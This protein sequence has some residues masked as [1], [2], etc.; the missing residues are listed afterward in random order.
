MPAGRPPYTLE[1]LPENWREILRTLGDEGKSKAHACV[2]LGISFDTYLRFERDYPEFLEA[3]R[4]RLIRTEVW[5]QDTGQAMAAGQIE[6]GNATA[7]VFNMKN[8]FGWHDRQHLDHSSS[9][10]SMSPPS[11]IEIVAP[12]SKE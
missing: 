11:R 3:E 1:V 4:D 9:D 7:W 2:A 10:G 6:K 12:E 5:W 8:R